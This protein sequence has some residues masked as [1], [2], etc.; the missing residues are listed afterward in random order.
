MPALIPKPIVDIL[1]ISHLFQPFLQ[2]GSK[3]TYEK[4]GQYHKGYLSHLPNGTY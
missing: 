3:I 2:G 4:E 1:D